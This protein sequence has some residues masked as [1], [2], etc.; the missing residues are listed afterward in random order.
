MANDDEEGAL[1]AIFLYFVIPIIGFICI[2]VFIVVCCCRNRKSR[3]NGYVI[4]P[5]SVPPG[6]VYADGV[7]P[8][9][10]VVGNAAIAVV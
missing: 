8:V 6:V 7:T 10:Q 3:T 5:S 1:L 4:A 2:V 9:G